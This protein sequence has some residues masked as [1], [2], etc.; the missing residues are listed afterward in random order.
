MTRPA[1]RSATLQADQPGPLHAE[2]SADLLAA[3]DLLNLGILVIDREGR[4]TFA[5]RAAKTLMQDRD[6]QRKQAEAAA[7]FDRIRTAAAGRGSAED[8]STL[9]G[10]DRKPLIGLIARRRDAGTEASSSVVFIGD[11]TVQP[12][13]DLRPIARL[14]ALTRAETR[15]LDALVRG[16]R[17]ATYAKR[18]GITL[19]TAKSYLKQLFGKTRTRRQSDLLR[20]ILGTPLLRLV[21]ARSGADAPE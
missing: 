6:G 15:L 3:L 2:I 1:P 19:N 18:A 14:Y 7:L 17:V 21:S 11:P 8:C 12:P 10:A 13:P 9:T 5:N 16:E 4:T 20:L